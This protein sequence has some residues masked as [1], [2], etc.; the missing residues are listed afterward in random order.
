MINTE[1]LEKLFIKYAGGE[2]RVARIF[3]YAMK[4]YGAGGPDWAKQEIFRVIPTRFKLRLLSLEGQLPDHERGTWL[5]QSPP[6][7]LRFGP[8]G[9]RL[10]KGQSMRNRFTKAQRRLLESGGEL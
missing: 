2:E 6:L 8:K 9:E 7:S 1:K 10:W 4:T 3:E 5:C